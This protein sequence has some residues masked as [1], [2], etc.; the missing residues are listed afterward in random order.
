LGWLNLNLNIF[1]QPLAALIPNVTWWNCTPPA[2]AGA[3]TAPG[4]SRTSG[5][6]SSK[7]MT[8]SPAADAFASLPVYL[9]NPAPDGTLTSDTPGKPTVLLALI[10]LLQH[11]TA[12]RT[13]TQ[14][15]RHCNHHVE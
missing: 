13:T 14:R 15:R 3:A 2:K 10:I 7:S 11:P 8:R 9:R 6:R 12:C 4:K 1:Q 5:T